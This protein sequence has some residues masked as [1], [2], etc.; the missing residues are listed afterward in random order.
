MEWL[1]IITLQSN[2]FRESG[3]DTIQVPVKS[4]AHCKTVYGRFL[5]GRVE[6]FSGWRAIHAHGQCL[7]IS[8][9]Q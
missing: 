8:N 2:G 9:D 7:R 4:E 1:L 6:R 3:I 5:D